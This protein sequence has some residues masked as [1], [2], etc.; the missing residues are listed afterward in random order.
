MV[1]AAFTLFLEKGKLVVMN[2]TIPILESLYNNYGS[3]SADLTSLF[4][5]KLINSHPGDF[6]ASSQARDVLNALRS[7]GLITWKAGKNQPDGTF[8]WNQLYEAN[9]GTMLHG[10]PV[11]LETCRVEGQLTV[12]GLF[13]M[14]ERKASKELSAS[15][16]T[17]NESATRLNS[18]MEK[19]NSALVGSTRIIM[20]AT[21]VQ[22]ILAIVGYYKEKSP[23]KIEVK[24]TIQVE[25]K[26]VPIDSAAIK[27]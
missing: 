20:V 15:T 21:V 11:T 23:S 6:A 4:V 26:A 25:Q 14:E 8:L 13:I 5:N 24:P 22:V 12:K 10:F 16:I 2:W 18:Q 3:T 17:F 1:Q 19:H 27:K 7:E 9:L